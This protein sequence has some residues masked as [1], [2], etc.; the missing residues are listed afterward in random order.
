MGVRV[1][2]GGTFAE[3]WV[4]CHGVGRASQDNE[5]V[6]RQEQH[7]AQAAVFPLLICSKGS[8]DRDS[9]DHSQNQIASLEVRPAFC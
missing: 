5:E 4:D 9:S 3:L 2:E 8:P 7:G 1:A 6:A